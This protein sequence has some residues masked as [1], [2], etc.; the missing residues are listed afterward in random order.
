MT[1]THSE[2]AVSFKSNKGHIRVYIVFRTAKLAQLAISLEKIGIAGLGQ[3]IN[4][5]ELQDKDL[6][7]LKELLEA[8]I[9]HTTSQP[10]ALRDP[11][12]QAS[13]TTTEAISQ[14]IDQEISALRGR[15]DALSRMLQE[16]QAQ[17]DAAQAVLAEAALAISQQELTMPNKQLAGAQ[18]RMEMSEG[19]LQSAARERWERS[20]MESEKAEW[21]TH[22]EMKESELKPQHQKA[23][24]HIETEAQWRTRSAMEREQLEQELTAARKAIRLSNDATK[25]EIS[26][27]IVLERQLEHRT[28]EQIQPELLKALLSVETI[29]QQTSQAASFQHLSVPSASINP[30]DFSKYPFDAEESPDGS[31]AKRRRRI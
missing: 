16:A 31:L 17:R 29:A 28:R 20:Y 8:R 26:K 4:I 15:C 6:S 2:H 3:H 11:A 7:R 23:M 25:L 22:S 10:N 30:A 19:P 21:S 18:S 5:S 24:D 1:E 14:P 9:S 13:T 12:L 27:R